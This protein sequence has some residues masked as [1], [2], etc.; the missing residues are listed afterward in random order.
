MLINLP[1]IKNTSK[2]V[3]R[4]KASGRG[5]TSGRGM[6]GQKSRTGATTK[7]ISGGQTK[8]YLALPKR[9]GF[10]S[11]RRKKI[12]VI[13]YDKILDKFKENEKVSEEEVVKRFAIDQRFDFIKVIAKGK[14]T[15]KRDFDEKIVLSG[16]IK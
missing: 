5:K 8:Y 1:K 11:P 10:R 2:R 7:F 3:G 14:L 13:T 6:N 12:I 16:S 9:G 4:G 15:E